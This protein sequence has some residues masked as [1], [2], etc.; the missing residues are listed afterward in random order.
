MERTSRA[1]NWYSQG[2]QNS[3]SLSGLD[4]RNPT[5]LILHLRHVMFINERLN[6]WVCEWVGK[7]KRNQTVWNLR[8]RLVCRSSAV[9]LFYDALLDTGNV[10]LWYVS[11]LLH[12][13]IENNSIPPFSLVFGLKKCRTPSKASVRFRSYERVR[14]L[15]PVKCRGLLEHTSGTVDKNDHFWVCRSFFW[16]FFLFFPHLC[17]IILFSNNVLSGCALE[18][19]TRP[20][21][22]MF[23]GHM[24]IRMLCRWVTLACEIVLQL[25]GVWPFPA[26]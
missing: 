24:L 11:S 26:N 18:E 12:P 17:S 9:S 20:S 22:V 8:P 14:G 1:T 13:H 15:R 2:F 25:F 19:N 7:R 10:D 4:V 5:Q 6:K 21:W 3:D 16:H 23:W